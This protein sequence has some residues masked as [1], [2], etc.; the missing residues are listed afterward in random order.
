MYKKAC[1][2]D[3]NTGCYNLGVKYLKGEGVR[4]DNSRALDLFGKAC[5]LKSENGCNAYAKLKNIGV[6]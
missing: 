1:E 4:K 5:D 6:K 3:S 2:G